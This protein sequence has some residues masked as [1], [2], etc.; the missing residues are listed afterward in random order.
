MSEPTI[1]I[2]ERPVGE[3]P[4]V[5]ETNYIAQYQDGTIR[6]ALP[7]GTYRLA[8]PSDLLVRWVPCENCDDYGNTDSDTVRGTPDETCPVCGGDGGGWKI[9]TGMLD[10]VD[11]L[12]HRLRVT[13][14]EAEKIRNGVLDALREAQG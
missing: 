12:M 13:R 3:L 2:T 6:S 5:E 9:D 14:A 7:P 11:F 4:V 8:G 1:T 10:A